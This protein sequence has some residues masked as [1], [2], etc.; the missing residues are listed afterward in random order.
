MV[1]LGR[2][3]CHQ[4]ASPRNIKTFLLARVSRFAVSFAILCLCI[5]G[6]LCCKNLQEFLDDGHGNLKGIKMVNVRWEKIDGQMRLLPAL[7]HWRCI[8]LLW[9]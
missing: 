4:L 2:S 3:S 9:L 7:F 8:V 1:V 6:C 5:F